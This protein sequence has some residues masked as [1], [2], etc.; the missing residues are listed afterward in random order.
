[1]AVLYSKKKISW[2][3]LIQSQWLFKSR[4]CSLAGGRRG[5]QW[6]A[7][8]QEDWMWHCCCEG[9]GACEKEPSN[10][11]ELR[12]PPTDNQQGTGGLSPTAVGSETMLTA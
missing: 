10:D 11:T 4:E 8:H 3:G 9:G 6:N 12:E 1:M 5:S 7:K 2:L